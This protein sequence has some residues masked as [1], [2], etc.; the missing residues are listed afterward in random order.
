MKSIHFSGTK[1][2]PGVGQRNR[3]VWPEHHCVLFHSFPSSVLIS[4]Q[5]QKKKFPTQFLWQSRKPPWVQVCWA[6]IQQAKRTQK[7]QYLQPLFIIIIRMLTFLKNGSSRSQKSNRSRVSTTPKEA[8]FFVIIPSLP[9]ILSGC[10][11]HMPTSSD[12]IASPAHVVISINS[13][14]PSRNR[15]LGTCTA[16][17]ICRVSTWI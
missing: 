5:L 8:F 2:V 11:Y 9:L 12:Q 1:C 10:S 4:F 7:V 15:L 17:L 14:E 3:M 6:W 13:E 16:F